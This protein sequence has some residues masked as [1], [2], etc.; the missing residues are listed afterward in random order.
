MDVTP[1]DA[2]LVALATG[3]AGT[4]GFVVRALLNKKPDNRPPGGDYLKELRELQQ[5]VDR[6]H[7]GVNA[8]VH[9]M[10]KLADVQADLART[11]DRI[12]LLEEREAQERREE[13]E[14]RRALARKVEEALR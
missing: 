7:L 3:M 10:E 6:I 12:A 2:G 9:T 11:M 5:T 8:Q 1:V 13:A 14:E 4:L